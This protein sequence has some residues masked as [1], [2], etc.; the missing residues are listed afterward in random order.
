[1]E[2]LY[3]KIFQSN[4][5]GEVTRALPLHPPPITTKWNLYEILMK[6]LWKSKSYET[7]YEFPTYED[8]IG[9]WYFGEYV[10]FLEMF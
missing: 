2:L 7:S 3:K 5:W 6:H 9:L 10:N 8:F 4:I 1:M